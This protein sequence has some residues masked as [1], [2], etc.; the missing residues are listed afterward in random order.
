[1][2]ARGARAQQSALPVIGFL[3]GESAD[4][5]T[6]RVA[7]FRKGLNETGYVEG[8]NVTIEYHWLEG[9]YDRLSALVADLARRRVAVIATPGFTQAAFVAK[10]ATT[11]IPI[12][13]GVAGD[14][15]N[16]VWSP[17]SPGPAPTRRASTFSPGR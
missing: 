9:Q 6:H 13:F 12:V 3:N 4:A 7:E 17:A 10:A 1:M 8:Q 15:V 11:A 14:P 5:A 16:L 2:A